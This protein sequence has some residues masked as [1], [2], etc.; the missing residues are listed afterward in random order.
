MNFDIYN[1]ILIGFLILLNISLII[2]LYTVLP[3]TAHPIVK[4]SNFIIAIV[5]AGILFFILFFLLP[6]PKAEKE[7]TFN[8]IRS[9]VFIYAS[10]FATNRIMMRYNKKFP[11]L[12]LHL[13]SLVSMVCTLIIAYIILTGNMDVI[14]NAITITNYF[15]FGAAILGVVT[16]ILS[17][18]QW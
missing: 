11:L 8:T 10:I 14:Q 2:E 3:K 6:F 7:L 17:V 18:I 13:F 1:I 12:A 5:I 16:F 4:M 9:L 15:S